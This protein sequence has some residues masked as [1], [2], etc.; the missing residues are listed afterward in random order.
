[1]AD[2]SFGR[3]LR[4][5]LRRHELTQADFARRLGTSTSTVSYWI[6]D[7]RVPNPGSCDRIADLFHED[8]DLVLTIA[9][10]R[11]AV[12][13]LAPDDPRRELIALLT[14][15][16][17]NEDREHAIRSLLEDFAKRPL[18]RTVTQS[19]GTSGS[20]KGKR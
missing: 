6:N 9:G 7:E 1:M 19:P 13:P 17:L 8:V 3:W 20:P 2:I 16:D 11:P 4:Q 10:H 15:I 5:Q 12:E 14:R 18:N